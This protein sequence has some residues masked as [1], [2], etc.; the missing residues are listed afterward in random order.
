MR[1]HFCRTLNVAFANIALLTIAAGGLSSA[2]AQQE[3]S[4]PI[5]RQKFVES[6]SHLPAPTIVEVIPILDSIKVATKDGVLDV[7]MLGPDINKAEKGLSV[8][9][10]KV[11]DRISFLKREGKDVLEA[12]FSNIGVVTSLSPLALKIEG[13]VA[14]IARGSKNTIIRLVGSPLTLQQEIQDLMVV[15]TKNPDYTNFKGPIRSEGPD[16]EIVV[17]IPKPEGLQFT[18]STPLN[19]SDLAA[20]QK[21]ALELT[22]EPEGRIVSRSVTVIVEKP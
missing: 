3:E 22:I 13:E 6:W 5:R 21:V 20:G 4:A 15:T 7:Y 18:R 14:P 19:S 8:A 1:T 16:T 17:T 12:D 2:S 10:L 11:G 9:Q